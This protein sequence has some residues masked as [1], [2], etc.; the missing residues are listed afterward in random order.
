VIESTSSRLAGLD[1][2]RGWAVIAVV[3]FHSGILRAGWVGVDVFMALSGF[4]ITGVIVRE[5]DTDG[6]LRLG[7]F[8]RRRVRRLVPALLLTLALIAIVTA[9]EPR[10]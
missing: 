2:L 4:L 6:R 10:D 5:L 7:A 3:A 1:G 9:V 8:W